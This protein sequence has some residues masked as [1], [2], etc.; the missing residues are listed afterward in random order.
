MIRIMEIIGSS[1]GSVTGLNKNF[2]A[3]D[4]KLSQNRL[5][6]FPISST[7]IVISLP[8]V[9]LWECVCVSVRFCFVLVWAFRWANPPPEATYWHHTGNVGYKQPH[10][11]CFVSKRCAIRITTC[12]H[13]FS[14]L[15]KT[16]SM[17]AAW[18]FTPKYCHFW[19]RFHSRAPRQGVHFLHCTHAN[20][21]WVTFINLKVRLLWNAFIFYISFFSC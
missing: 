15:Q 1:L 12:S 8:T 6:K 16:M 11:N 19:G 14:I 4:G 3:I 17:P 13:V 2:Q 7:I 10:A 9:S 18:Q 21:K 5:R 20:C